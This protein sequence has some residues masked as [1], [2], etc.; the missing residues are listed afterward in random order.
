MDCKT[1]VSEYKRWILKYMRELWKSENVEIWRAVYTFI[2]HYTDRERA[3][4]KKGRRNK[5]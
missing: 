2:K 5:R 4:L 3:L 1:P